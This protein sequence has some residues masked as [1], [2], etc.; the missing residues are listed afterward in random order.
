MA[1][2]IGTLDLACPHCGAQH[3]VTWHRLPVR[4]PY[5]LSCR[6]CGGVMREGKGV[7][8]YDA[9]RLVN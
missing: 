9:P 7:H 2:E 1:F 4:E 5:R 3:Q 8:D 6:V